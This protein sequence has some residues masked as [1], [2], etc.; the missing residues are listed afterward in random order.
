MKME[1]KFD[2]IWVLKKL[3]VVFFTAA[4]CAL[5]HWGDPVIAFGFIVYIVLNDIQDIES[6]LYEVK[7]ERSQ[8]WKSISPK[9]KGF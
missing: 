5:Y 6:T 7:E 8:A 1:F 3:R 9:R 2:W 4:F